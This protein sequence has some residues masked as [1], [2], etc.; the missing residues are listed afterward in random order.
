MKKPYI[1]RWDGE[2][3]D[4]NTYLTDEEIEYLQKELEKEVKN[5]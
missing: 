5:G 1:F 4:P 3:V 2:L